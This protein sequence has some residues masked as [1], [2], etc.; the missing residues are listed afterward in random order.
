MKQLY[1]LGC[2]YSALEHLRASSHFV[3]VVDALDGCEPGVSMLRFDL[4]RDVPHHLAIAQW[5]GGRGIRATFFVHTRAECFIPDAL[6]EVEALGHEVG[7]H[8]ECLD[9]CGGDWLQARSLFLRE[10]ELFREHGLSLRTCCS[11]GE[12][13]I[14]RHGYSANWELMQRYPHLLAEAGIA[15]EMYQWLRLNPLMYA[16]DTFRGV[17]KFFGVVDQARTQH[18]TLMMLVHAHRWRLSPGAIAGEVTTDLL[19]YVRNRVLGRRSYRLPTFPA[20]AAECSR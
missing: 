20:K 6:R 3:R 19:Q 4:E 7:Y 16:T 5:L 12:N 1:S 18:R 15:C 14:R 9:R 17:T 11:H 10:V 8:H 2:L 13:G